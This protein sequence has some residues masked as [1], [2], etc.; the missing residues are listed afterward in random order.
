[1]SAIGMISTQTTSLLFCIMQIFLRLDVA[2]QCLHIAQCGPAW[3]HAHVTI[4]VWLVLVGMPSCSTA[5]KQSLNEGMPLE[6]F[7]WAAQLL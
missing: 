5:V 4:V 2:D 7:R 3:Q 1:M 6:E